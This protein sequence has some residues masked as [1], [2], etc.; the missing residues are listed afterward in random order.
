MEVKAPKI[1][2]V[3]LIVPDKFGDERGFFSETYNKKCFMEAGIETEF[4]QD[5]HSQSRDKGVLK[6]PH[7][8]KPP[9]PK[10]N[11]CACL[12]GGF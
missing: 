1:P 12:R 11:W 10:P 5:N 9:F 6:G 3:K 8:Q 2:D 4:V 7:Y